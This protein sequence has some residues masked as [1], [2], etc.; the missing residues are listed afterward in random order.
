MAEL[1]NLTQAAKLAGVSRG[2]IYRAIRTGALTAARGGRPGRLTLID[3]DALRA[4]CDREG[5]RTPDLPARPEDAPS[6]PFDPTAIV[7][8]QLQYFVQWVDDAIG[9]ANDRLMERLERAIEASVERAVA[10]AME[11][12]VRTERP[13]HSERSDRSIR[14][15]ERAQRSIP[16]PAPSSPT[17]ADLLTR[18]RAMRYDHGLSFRAIADQLNAEGVPTLSGKG[19]WQ[20]GTISN[21]LSGRK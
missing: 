21:L 2:T 1:L 20:K 15:G 5:L 9:H 17:K 12:Y 8:G 4:W 16:R 18:I 19:S 14:A 11:R 6:P 3:P 13:V 10:R 7:Q